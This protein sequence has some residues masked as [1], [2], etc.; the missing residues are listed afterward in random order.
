[1]KLGEFPKEILVELAKMYAQN[2]QTLDGLWFRDVEARFRLEA[3][4]TLNLK[5]WERQPM[6]EAE[7]IKWRNMQSYSNCVK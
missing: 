5:N 2:W 3:T 6:I 1:M 7:G 4:A